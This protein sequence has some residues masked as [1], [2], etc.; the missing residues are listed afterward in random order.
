[1]ENRNFTKHVHMEDLQFIADS[2]LSAMTPGEWKYL[3][4][5]VQSILF[6][7]DRLED[8]IL[9]G[10]KHLRD[11]FHNLDAIEQEEINNASALNA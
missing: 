9:A 7:E 5:R 4:V 2:D 8:D 6:D 10:L 11:F 1:M 3:I